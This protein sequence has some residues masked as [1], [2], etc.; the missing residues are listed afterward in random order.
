MPSNADALWYKDAVIYQV[1]VRA[2]HDSGLRGRD[3][4]F[5]GLEEKLPYLQELGINTIWLMPIF[6]FSVTR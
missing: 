2:F 6:S 1:H 4:T 3:G 5:R